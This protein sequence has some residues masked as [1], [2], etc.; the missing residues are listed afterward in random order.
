MAP[1]P[2]RLRDIFYGS[3]LLLP[4]SLL[5]HHAKWDG[6]SAPDP[7]LILWSF[8]ILIDS[9]SF[10]NSIFQLFGLIDYLIQKNFL[11]SICTRPRW[12]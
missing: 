3:M 10:K 11:D 2:L 7:A 4:T 9:L 8:L 5:H 12:C 6:I 1:N